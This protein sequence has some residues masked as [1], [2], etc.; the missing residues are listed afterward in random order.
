MLF[1]RVPAALL[2][3]HNDLGFLVKKLF[4]PWP[5]RDALKSYI[6][7]SGIFYALM[8]YRCFKYW[9][10]SGPRSAPA[11]ITNNERISRFPLFTKKTLSFVYFSALTST[12]FV[13]ELSH[14]LLTGDK[15]VH[16]IYTFYL[17]K[18]D[19]KIFM[20]IFDR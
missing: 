3:Q 8:D 19:R 16:E 14:S 20:G 12:G 9:S 10:T 11:H 18:H 5:L 1:R 15:N 13:A 2:L 4:F 7:A 6:L 17:K